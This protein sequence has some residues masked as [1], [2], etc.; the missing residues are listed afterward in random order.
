MLFKSFLLASTAS[1]TCMHNLSKYKRATPGKVEVGTFGY[2]GLNGPLNLASL[3]A[4]NSACK[5]GRNQS[6]I[7][8]G[9]F[10]FVTIFAM[11]CDGILI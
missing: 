5:T 6:P 4:N 9:M 7:N 11:C 2:T 3:N 8:I 1:A 10:L